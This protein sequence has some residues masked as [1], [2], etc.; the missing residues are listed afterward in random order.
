M[1]KFM[2]ATICLLLVVALGLGAVLVLGLNGT[3]PVFRFGSVQNLELANR[4]VFS[5]SG[6]K[7]LSV[8]YSS[9]RITL[10]PSATDEIVVEE[11]MSRWED[12][13]LATVTHEGDSLAVQ[14]GRRS[15]NIGIFNFWRAEVR[16]YVPAM[17]LGHVTLTNSSGSIRG[18]G[19][20]SFQSFT[21]SNT[22]GSIK[23]QSIGAEED[24]TLSG[25][26]GSISADRL[27]AGGQVYAEN[28]SG[29]IKMGEVEGEGITLAASSG[30]VKCESATAKQVQATSSSGSIHFGYISGEFAIKNTSGSLKV[31]SGSGHGSVEGSSGSVEVSLQA[32]TGDLFLKTTSGSCKLYLPRDTAL[33]F[34]GH[35][36]SGSVKTPEDA[37]WS[38]FESRDKQDVKGTLG[39]DAKHTVE[40]R[41]SSGSVRLEWQ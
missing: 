5:T 30:S 35:T 25:S 15:F 34:T 3:L 33:H 6:L 17:W 37:S 41:A 21:V 12:D 36:S 27:S 18:E 29:S 9:E 23:V 1:K 20:F 32:L 10:L 13:M 40:M 14:S 4:Q 39:K 8:S 19:D 16:V 38:E 24:I 2:I 31:E 28:T 7:N 26:S 11:Y 22:S